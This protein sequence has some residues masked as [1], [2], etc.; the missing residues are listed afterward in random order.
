MEAVNFLANL[1]KQ[2]KPFILIVG[3]AI[4]GAIGGIDFLTGFEFS[5]SVFYVIPI[6]IVAWLTSRFFGV[7]AS[8]ASALVWLGADYA[9]G[10]QYSHHLIPFWNTLIRLI[11][12]VIITLLLSTLRKVTEREIEFSRVDYL[13]GAVNSRLFFELAQREI[14]RFQRYQH[15]FTLAYIDLDNFKTVNDRFGHTVGDQVLRTVVSAARKYTRKTD[16]IA[17]LGGDEFVVLM[18]ETGLEFARV[19][20]SKLQS[21]LLEAMRL[22]NWP[23]T[24]SIGILTC[25]AVPPSAKELVRI[26]DDLMY[27][28]KHAGKNALKYHTYTG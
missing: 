25:R 27:S 26:A 28:V 20:M 23:I 21:G 7:V 1:E 14:D 18:P 3:F 2:S 16:V 24:F 19:A 12:F 6:S 8:L 4:I 15:P 10:H 13:T 11:F 22:N 9:T 5:F 17:R